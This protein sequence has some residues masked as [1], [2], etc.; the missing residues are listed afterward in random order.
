MSDAVEMKEKK[1]ESAN[2]LFRSEAVWQ[3]FFVHT[4]DCVLDM[5]FETHKMRCSLPLLESLRL[6]PAALPHTLEQWLELCHPDDYAKNLEFNRHILEW[7]ENAFSLERRLY[8]GDGVYRWFRMNAVCI[9]DE[10]NKLKRLIAVETNISDQG[11]DSP[12]FIERLQALENEV[13]LLK[14]ENAHLASRLTQ[15]VLREESLDRRVRQMTYMVDATSDLLFCCDAEGRLLACNSAFSSAA[16]HNPDLKK[17]VV[18]LVRAGHIEAEWRCCDAYGR[19][20]SFLAEVRGVS[21]GYVGAAR[22]VTELEETRADMERLKLLFGGRVYFKKTQDSQSSPSH[23]TEERSPD[24]TGAGAGDISLSVMLETCLQKTIQVFSTVSAFFPTRAAQLENLLKASRGTELEVGV[25]GITSS[26]KSAFIN[27]MM[28]EKLLPEETRATSNLVVRCR[29]GKE[30]A[31]TVITKDDKRKSVSGADLT[32][33]W[34]ES[35]ASERL[36]QKNE[37]NVAFL[38]WTSPG[39]ALPEG[40][41]LLDTP[42]LD[43]CDLPEHSELVLRRLLPNLDIVLYVTSIRNRFK[44]A[45]L[46]L[47]E[48]AIEHDQ[49]VIFLLSQIDLEQDDMEGRKVVLSRGQK[50]SSYIDGLYKDI[51]SNFDGDSSIRQASVVAVS[52]KLASAHFY[53]RESE[54]WGASNFGALIRQLEVYRSN[55]HQCK[56]E[57]RARRAL[58]LLSRTAADIDLAVGRLSTDK[59]RAEESARLEK[60]RELRDAQRWANAEISAVR[61]EWRRQLDPEYHLRRLKKEIESANTV[62]GIKDRYERWGGEWAELVSLMIDRMDRARRS[63]REILSRHGVSSDDRAS[64]TIA[65]KSELPEFH[66]Y[67]VNEAQEVRVRGW[68]E[69]L[70]FWPRYSVFF[71]QDVDRNKMIEG[72]KDLIAERLRLLNDHLA[73]WENRMREDYCDLLYGELS[74]EDVALADTRRAAADVSVSR[75]TLLQVLRDIREQSRGIKSALS[76]LSMSSN[77]M[78]GGLNAEF[79]RNDY[80]PSINIVPASNDSDDTSGYGIFAPLLAS[81]KEQDIQSRFMG[82]EALRERKRIVFLGL[83]RHDSLRLLSRLV[84]D[85]AFF[86]L[87]KTEEGHDID[88][89][90]WIFRGSIP[91]ALSHVRVNLPDTLL[92]ETDIL[93]APCDNLCADGFSVDWNDIFAEWLPIV[94]IDIARIDSGLSDLARAPYAS[95]L[96]HAGHW[97]A[98]SG[99]GALFNARLADLLTDVPERLRSFVARRG[100]T[101]RA[102]WFVYENYDARYTDFMLWGQ[103]MNWDSGDDS[104]LNKWQ[105]GGRDFKFPFSEFRMRLAIEGAKRKSLS[106]RQPSITNSTDVEQI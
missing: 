67:V 95:A 94:H 99:Q 20:R 2:S 61:N 75:K 7:A 100:Y 48:A 26:G 62:K 87:M 15:K 91:P 42:G 50:L 27:A 18:D 5:D 39:A 51:D 41:V 64:G 23:E 84:H 103:D 29:K 31:V 10:K 83:R 1:A 35:V 58:V 12:E 16:A 85:A 70:E 17:W 78:S 9:R 46:E 19:S 81:L 72:A 52:S 65:V 44:T 102:E 90:D 37:Q 69:A 22:D 97:V 105:S 93:I 38:E 24:E 80:E 14:K 73:W 34:M 45:D 4:L 57:T 47:L 77:S 3:A 53:D 25:V 6:T 98:A 8:C 76:S 49:R 106:T 79:G 104:F 55:L 60:I 96:A 88:E 66:R 30:R 89:R 13:A 101:G 21:D 82:L 63:C 54:E 40:L 56:F 28:G 68:F 43:A 74:R 92:R 59:V 71:R 32:A 11:R 36:N 86:D 33:A